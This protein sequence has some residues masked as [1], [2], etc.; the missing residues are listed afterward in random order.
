MLMLNDADVGCY[1]NGFDTLILRAVK[2]LTHAPELRDVCCSEELESLLI[3]VDC[4]WEINL[5]N[6][7]GLGSWLLLCS[8][9]ICQLNFLSE[10]TLYLSVCLSLGIADFESVFLLLNKC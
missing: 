4:S 6:M 5:Y 1:G 3:T 8:A 9:S 2:S 10:S 7:S